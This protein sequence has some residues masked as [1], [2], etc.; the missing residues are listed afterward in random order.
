MSEIGIHGFIYDESILYALETAKEYTRRLTEKDFPDERITDKKFA[1]AWSNYMRTRRYG[2]FREYAAMQQQGIHDIAFTYNW[3][4]VC[5]CGLISAVADLERQ[6]SDVFWAEPGHIEVSTRSLVSIFIVR[7][8]ISKSVGT[9][10][11]YWCENCGDIGATI[12]T[13]GGE[14]SQIGLKAIRKSHSCRS[15]SADRLAKN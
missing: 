4:L 11:H 2:S 15:K 12:P 10:L 6:D 3:R 8:W 9:R 13:R 14:V 7:R 1:A 5:T